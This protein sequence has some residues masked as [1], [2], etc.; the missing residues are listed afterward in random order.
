[1]IEL[2]NKSLYLFLI[3]LVNYYGWGLVGILLLL[4]LDFDVGLRDERRRFDVASNFNQLGLI[5][6]QGNVEDSSIDIGCSLYELG[7][8]RVIQIEL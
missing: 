6:F 4:S 7:V 5:G 2:F 1:M 8:N 3:V